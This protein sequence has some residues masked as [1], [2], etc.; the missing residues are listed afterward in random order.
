MYS[1]ADL[2]MHSEENGTDLGKR[3]HLND[4]TEGNNET[5]ALATENCLRQVQEGRSI[6]MK[7][8]EWIRMKKM[9][10]TILAKKNDE[11]NFSPQKMMSKILAKKNDEQF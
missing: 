7:E 4:E 2:G 5:Q 10:S 3:T 1:L 9:M 8:E 6:I 11:H